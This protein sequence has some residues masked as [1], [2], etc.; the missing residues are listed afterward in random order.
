MKKLLLC[1]LLTG[2]SSALDSPKIEPNESDSVV[3]K[4]KETVTTSVKTFE[5]VDKSINKKVNNVVKQIVTLKE[6][7]K[8]LSKAASVKVIIRD[9]IYITEKK[10]FW[11]KTKTIKDSSQGIQVDTLENQ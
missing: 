8:T 3:V 4:S 2:C 5:Q 6:E 9:T 1:L 7:N 10:N 11:G